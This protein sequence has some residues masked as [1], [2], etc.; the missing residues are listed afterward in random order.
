MQKSMSLKYAPSA[1]RRAPP[2]LGQR[3]HPSRARGY[4]PRT[5][6]P[7]I[8]RHDYMFQQFK[9]NHLLAGTVWA[10]LEAHNLISL[11]PTAPTR[12]LAG[13]TLLMGGEARVITWYP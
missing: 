13:R 5:R 11:G 12:D 2:P 4:I 7:K 10:A 9:V 8:L 3:R 6:T 1:G